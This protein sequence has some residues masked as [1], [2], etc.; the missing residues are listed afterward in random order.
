MVQTR[1]VAVYL[2]ESVP[3]AARS[4]QLAVLGRLRALE[5]RGVIDEVTVETWANHVTDLDPL[6]AGQLTAF[7]GF[8]TW[9]RTHDSDIHPAFDAHDCVCSFT[10]TSFR[11]TTFP[12]VC[13]AIYV[14]DELLTVY[15]HSGPHGTRT[16]SDGLAILEAT[17]T[18]DPQPPDLDAD[19]PTP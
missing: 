3:L 10:D 15:P 14:D 4:R 16:V 6:A 17:T 7:S 2:R 5:S 8:E 11:R 13:L 18:L 9:A 19:T 12:V 1:R